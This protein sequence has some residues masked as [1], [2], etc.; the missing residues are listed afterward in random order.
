ME[1]RDKGAMSIFFQSS[2]YLCIIYIFMYVCESMTSCTFNTF[3]IHSGSWSLNYILKS[4][5]PGKR[6]NLEQVS[7]VVQRISEFCID[8][9]LFQNSIKKN[10][11]EL[12][13]ILKPKPLVVVEHK[14]R[15]VPWY[16]RRTLA[17]KYLRWPTFPQHFMKQAVSQGGLSKFAWVTS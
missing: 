2:N 8:I 9:S 10:W 16:H 12:V 17:E 11:K 15:S 7:Q 14:L 1:P 5:Q 3:P 13:Y 6:R 4:H